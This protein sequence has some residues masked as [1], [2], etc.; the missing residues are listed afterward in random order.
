MPRLLLGGSVFLVGLCLV[1]AH[2][3]APQTNGPAQPSEYQIERLAALGK[4]WGAVKFFHPFLTYKDIDWDGALV[5]AIPRVKAAGTPAEFLAA[6]NGMLDVLADP[7]T[8]AEATTDDPSA[9]PT[10]SGPRA[11]PGHFRIVDGYVVVSAPRL[12]EAMASGGASAG[13]VSL[14]AEIAKASG[15][16]LDCRFGSA[17]SDG[18]QSYFL[19]TSLNALLPMLVQGTV[20]LGTERY[21]LHN[22][23]PPQQGGSSGGY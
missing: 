20:P 18:E 14:Q 17:R 5:R 4:L 15:V 3:R 2:A 1:T 13:Q 8:R 19:N 6:I 11:E 9:A 21:R 7:A 10:A 16:V 12:A 23:Y 22:G